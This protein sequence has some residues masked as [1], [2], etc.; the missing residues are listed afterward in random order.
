MRSFNKVMKFGFALAV[1]SMVTA[2]SDTEFTKTDTTFHKYTVNVGQVDILF[3]VDNS[4]SMSTEQRRMAA[5]FPNFV[6]GLDIAGLDYRIGIITTDVMPDNHPD[7]DGETL[8]NGNL[9]AFPNGEYFLTPSTRN[10][11]T[12]FA[13]TIKRDETEVCENSNF[14]NCPSDDERGIYAARIAVEA[15]KKSFF[16]ENGHVAFVFL[17]DEDVRGF[18]TTDAQSP[19]RMPEP[20]DYPENL[21]SMVE[22]KL[23]SNTD[24]SA[25]AIV[26]TNELA[27]SGKTC[28]EEQRNQGGNNNIH[29]ALGSFYMAMT[30]PLNQS[31]INSTPGVL[32]GSFAGGQ[33]V[34]GT[35][36]SICA[37]DYVSELGSIKSV[38]SKTKSSERLRCTLITADDLDVRIDGD[39]TW[40]LNSTKDEITFSPALPPGK[41]FKLEY[42]CI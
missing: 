36:G 34:K 6:Q 10:I 22:A 26:V 2:C 13:A 15:N 4:G 3:V 14:T 11:E 1:F 38:L 9:L 7:Y 28:V 5:S 32:M 27:P 31:I 42:E 25:H 41:S 37:D 29:G 40:E 35:V 12:E 20:K 17:S 30:D 21:L 33:L 19:F 24:V 8:R 39:Y 18:G 23:G 16:R